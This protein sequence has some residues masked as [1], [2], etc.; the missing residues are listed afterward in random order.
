VTDADFDRP[1]YVDEANQLLLTK[2][3]MVWFWDHYVPDAAQ[4]AEPDASPIRATTLAG[5]PPAV[6]LT[7]EHDVLRDEGEAYAEKLRAAGVAVQHRRFPGQ[8]HGFFTFVNVLPGAEA[9]MSYVSGQI[10]EHLTDQ[11]RADVAV[12]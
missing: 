9:S 6:V 12:N 1:S 8:M 11:P 7:A 3:A 5:L 2:D 10:N 4:R